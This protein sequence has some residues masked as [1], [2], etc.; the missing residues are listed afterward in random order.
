[1]RKQ[2][3]YMDEFINL[4]AKDEVIVASELTILSLEDYVVL[5]PP[6]PHRTNPPTLK[7]KQQ[8]EGTSEDNETKCADLVSDFY[9]G[10]HQLALNKSNIAASEYVGISI[11]H[12]HILA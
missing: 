5:Q 3:L 7:S 4:D 1:M 6:I 2:Q 9:L 11:V 10:Y 12:D 8:V